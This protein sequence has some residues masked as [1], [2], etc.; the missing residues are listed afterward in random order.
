MFI[1]TFITVRS[2]VVSSERPFF[3]YYP[4]ISFLVYYIHQNNIT[5][6]I[7]TKPNQFPLQMIYQ[8]PFQSY[9][10]I[11]VITL[12]NYENSTFHKNYT[13]SA[14]S[15]QITLIL[16]KYLCVILKYRGRLSLH[17]YWANDNTELVLNHIT[18]LELL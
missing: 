18:W 17:S 12:V 2:Y 13:L 11:I 15:F 8:Y 1:L 4:P 9:K 10:C 7:S 3:L 14:L 16:S 6:V 5:L